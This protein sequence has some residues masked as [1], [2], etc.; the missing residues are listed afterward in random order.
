MG[1]MLADN[2]ATEV[3]IAA[4]LGVSLRTTSIYVKR[5]AQRRNASAALAKLPGMQAPALDQ[6]GAFGGDQSGPANTNV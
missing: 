6:P 1:N 3:E 4:V 2:G 5:P